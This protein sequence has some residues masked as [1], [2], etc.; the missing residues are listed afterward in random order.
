MK[1]TGVPL[2]GTD[3][4]HPKV[5]LADVVELENPQPKVPGDQIER[6]VSHCK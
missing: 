5:N 6:D 2:H 1:N 3:T 4:V